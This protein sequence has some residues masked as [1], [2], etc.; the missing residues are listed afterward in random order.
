MTVAD[1]EAASRKEEISHNHLY[2]V[3]GL[4]SSNL[5]KLAQGMRFINNIRC[6]NNTI[7]LMHFS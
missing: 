5:E 2:K 7:L 4:S 3:T 1:A 6:S